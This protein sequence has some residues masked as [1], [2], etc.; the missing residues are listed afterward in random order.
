MNKELAA[1]TTLSHYRIVSKLGAGGMGEVWLAEDTRLNRKFALKVLPADL[2]SHQDRMKRFHQEA[3]AAAAL[4]HPNI[5]HIYEIGEDNG[6]H[7]IAM[8]FIDGDTLRDLMHLGPMDLPELLRHLRHVAEGL[9]KAHAA[10]IVHRDLK[11]E[12]IMVTRDGH[13]KILDFGLAKLSEPSVLADSSSVDTEAATRANIKTDPGMVVGTVSYMSPEQA[14]GLRDIDERTDIWSLGL[15]IYEMVSGRLPFGFDGA[16]QMQILSQIIQKEAPPLKQ[17]A[18]AIPDELNR[19]VMKALEN[20]REDRYQSVKEML[21]DLRRL[22]KQLEREADQERTISPE[23]SSY[24]AT[25][26][27]QVTGM[28]RPTGDTVEAQAA[29]PTSSTE[30]IVTEI[31]RHKKGVIVLA[32]LTALA[33]VATILFLRSP[34]AD[35]LTERDT[36]LVP[37]FVNTTGDPVFDGTLKQALAVQLGQSPFLNILSEDRV[38]GALRFMGRAADERVTRDVG[39]EICQRQGLK[40]MLAGSIASLGNQYVITLEAINARTGDALAREQAEA[41]SKEQVLRALGEAATKLREKLGESLAS[42]QKFDAPIEQ[43]TTS[44]LEAFKAFSLGVE[45]QLKGNY[46][47]ATPLYKRAAEID[48]NFAL[49]YARLA[50]VYTNSGEHGLAGAAS[51][52]A[53]DLRDRVS[54]RERLFISMSYYSNVTREVEKYIETLELWKRT[55]PR[56]TV[57]RNNLALQYNDIGQYEKAVEEAREAI[58]LNPNAAP[59]HSNLAR[60][61]SGLNRFDEAKEVIRQA[62]AQKVETTFM[63]RILYSIA[64]IQGDEAAMKEQ[65]EWAIGKPEEHAAQNWQAE[66]AAFSGQLRKTKEFSSRAAELAQRRDLKEVVAQLVAGEAVREALLGDCEQVKA[67]TAKALS[68]SESQLASLS[69]ANAL[70]VCGELSQIEAITDELVKR[71]PQDTLLNKVFQPLIQAHAEMYRGNAGQ[72][73]QLLE[74]TR[75]FEGAALFQVAYLRGQAYLS[76]QKGAEAATEFQ[77]I[78]SHRGWQPATPLYPLAQL[79][80]ARAAVLSGD[81]TTARKAFQDFFALWKDADPEIRVLREAKQEYE[82]LK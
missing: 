73:I 39:L 10:G 65:I 29:R 71:Y 23:I 34:R 69:A 19:I 57:P 46:F 20:R 80:L 2:A 77:K 7:F 18:S 64:F 60:A 24:S 3:T 21:V 43:A 58:R 70:A 61:F 42:I 14:S 53:Y 12:N 26:T 45:Q 74:T 51:Q 16:T 68:I 5:A 33:L 78:L 6:T 75:P 49:A 36:I 4:N 17:S 52:K 30:Y 1:N 81:V 31:K 82:K 8:E 76:Q 37:D 54:E 35:A 56:D 11:P 50:G 22:S 72:A 66:T 62:L 67:K 9:A 44:S 63:H 55:Y 25:S 38:R 79:G 28:Q 15:V 40:A 32:A 48:P 41:E 47:E 27:T 59:L 13:A